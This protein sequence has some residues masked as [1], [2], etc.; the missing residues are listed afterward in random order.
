MR[1]RRNLGWV[2]FLTLAAFG[3]A[4]E[5]IP[6]GR[7]DATIDLATREGVTLVGGKWRYH[8]TRIIEVDF[9]GPGPDRQPT[10]STVVFETALDDYTEIGV[11][12]ELSR[13]LGQRGGSPFFFGDNLTALGWILFLQGAYAVSQPEMPAEVVTPEY[14]EAI[15][16]HFRM[17]PAIAT[18]AILVCF[19]TAEVL[20]AVYAA[21]LPFYAIPINLKPAPQ[22]ARAVVKESL[23]DGAPAAS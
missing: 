19:W 10:G 12:G 23:E 9:R 4:G 11:D 7:P 13:Y 20:L 16:S 5:T 8:N 3:H 22:A 18:F 1:I 6:S 17:I 15:R 21:L 14:Q 2:I